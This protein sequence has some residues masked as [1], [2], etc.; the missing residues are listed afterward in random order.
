MITFEALREKNSMKKIVSVWTIV[1][2]V[3]LFG[4]GCNEEVEINAPYKSTT[5]V[6]GL[7]DPDP[8]NDGVFDALD[9]QWVRITRTFLGD[10]N[11]NDYAAIRDS[12][13]YKESDFVSKVVQQIDADGVVVATFDLIAKTV[14]NKSVNGIF[15]GPEQT[16]YYFIQPDG[17]K[18]QDKYRIA[19]DFAHKEDISATTEIVRNEEINFLTPQVDGSI[20]LAQ[21]SG[22]NISYPTTSSIKWNAA[23]NVT[24]YSAT[25][26]FYYTEFLYETTEWTGTPII[27][28]RYIDFPLG[29]IDAEGTESNITLRF[30]AR[31]FFTYLQGKIEANPLIKRVIGEPNTAETRPFDLLLSMG[32]SQLSTY[33]EVNSP[34]SGVVQE[35]PV[36]TNINNG[37]GLWAS[38]STKRLNDLKLTTTGAGGAPLIGNLVALVTSEY[39]VDLNFCDE[40]SSATEYT[41]D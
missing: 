1:G 34:V 7:I 41:C 31:S 16:L 10:G 6:F 13:E 35:R 25:L 40:N 33:I 3:A 27:S 29:S 39:T 32:S 9:T 5:I 18:T 26:R 17:I 37:L 22:G 38:R 21:S 20:T 28:E 12:S 4:L 8:N 19:L 30:N 11:N 23:D 14:A 36:H 24:S 2:L 15:Y